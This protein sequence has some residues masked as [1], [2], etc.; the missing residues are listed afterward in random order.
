MF[1]LL[2]FSINGEL[3]TCRVMDWIWYFNSKVKRIN[4]EDVFDEQFTLTL[5]GEGS[6]IGC[7]SL[8]YYRSIWYRRAKLYKLPQLGAIKDSQLS[9]KIKHHLQR[10]LHSATKELYN[11]LASKNWLSKPDT[12]V[13]NKFEV[14]AVAKGIGLTVPDSILTNSK[15]DVI[16]FKERNGEIILKCIS[17]AE[18]FKIG[19]ASYVTYTS[20]VSAE[21]IEQLQEKFFPTFFQQYIHKRYELRVFYLDKKLFSMAIFSQEDKQTEIDFRRYNH[22]YPNR[23][24]PYKLPDQLTVHLQN[25]MNALNLNTG[26]IDLIKAKS[27]EYV[28][29]EINPVGQ[30]GMV[31]SPCNFY[32]EKLIAKHLINNSYY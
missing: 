1:N 21:F 7:D 26:S 4:V 27:G 5:G 29:L 8:E 28:F 16:T 17:D 9:E 23:M 31:S 12:S 11:G 25:L 19:D 13:L 18:S 3:S 14:L 20:L 6:R 22:T 15:S 32:L 30:F 2:I 24:V 10:E